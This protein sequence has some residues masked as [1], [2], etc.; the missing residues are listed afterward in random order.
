MNKGPFGVHQVEFSVKSVPCLRNWSSI[1][2]HANS[3]GHS[4]LISIGHNGGGFV[5]DTDFETG[6]APVNKLKESNF[7][8]IVL[9]EFSLEWDFSG[10]YLKT[11]INNRYTFF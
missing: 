3:S 2:K 1:G 6:W 4:S 8:P 9:S 5:V 11:T 10:N 7:M